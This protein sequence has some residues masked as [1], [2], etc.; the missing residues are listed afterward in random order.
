MWKRILTGFRDRILTDMVRLSQ[1]VGK[2]I[3]KLF[4]VQFQLTLNMTHNL[5]GNLVGGILSRCYF[6]LNYAYCSCSSFP[7][8]ADMKTGR[9]VQSMDG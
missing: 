1:G 2:I 7:F 9:S 5:K 3:M 8:K 4:P 6:P